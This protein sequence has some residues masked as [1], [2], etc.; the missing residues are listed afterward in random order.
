TGAERA[1]YQEKQPCSQVGQRVPE[2]EGYY[3]SSDAQAGDKGLDRDSGRLE[4]GDQ[5]QDE[6]DRIDRAYKET[7]QQRV[8]SDASPVQESFERPANQR[9]SN[10][11]DYDGEQRWNQAAGQPLASARRNFIQDLLWEGVDGVHSGSR[12]LSPTGIE[13][14]QITRCSDRCA[15]WSGLFRQAGGAA[16]GNRRAF[17]TN[18]LRQSSWKLNEILVLSETV[19]PN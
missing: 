16:S 5:R 9:G 18:F 1:V 10:H 6:D 11:A 12:S 14:K 2:A 8:G 19:A 15:S 17:G 7:R 4:P 3:Y 13:P